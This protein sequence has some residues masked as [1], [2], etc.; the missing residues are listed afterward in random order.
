MKQI[1]IHIPI[2]LYAFDELSEADRKLVETAKEM[3]RHSYSPYSH[4]SVGAA[5]LLKDGQVFPGCNQENAAFPVGLCAER[6]AFFAAGAQAPGVAPV[7]VAIAAYTQGAFTDK[8]VTPCGSCRQALLEA[9]TRF[10]Q[11]IR[12][13]L[14]GTEG[15]Y[16]IPSI[17]NLLPLNFDGSELAVDS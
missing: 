15:V 8:P 1:S 14:Y 4:F 13:L 9:E 5:L 3:T 2:V 10:G 6:S 12:V 16:V 7:A 11:P 17:A